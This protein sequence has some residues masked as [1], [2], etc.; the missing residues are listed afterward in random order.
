MAF[1]DKVLGKDDHESK[2]R[3]EIKSLELRKATVF[4]T[5]D[6][7]IA[8]LFNERNSQLQAAGTAAYEA[9]KKEEQAELGE[10]W[11]CIV[12]LDKKVEEQKEKKIEMG[13]KY[14]EEI[15]LIGGS[16]SISS[17]NSMLFKTC[18]KCS[19]QVGMG[20]VF[21]QTCGERVQ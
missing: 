3:Q 9:W 5:I 19:A 10:F 13:K 17:G 20:D 8:R 7:E 12:D 15:R 21:C 14:D 1:L 4:S 18:P 11:N 16:L 2:L 6:G